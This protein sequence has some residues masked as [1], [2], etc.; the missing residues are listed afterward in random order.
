MVNGHGTLATHERIDRSC[1]VLGSAS[2]RRVI[3]AL[4]QDSP[5]TPDELA[6][7]VV[8]AGISDGRR[9]VLTSLV[10]THLPKLAEADVVDYDGPE[11]AVALS[12]GVE[13]LEP[14]LSVTARQETDR[15]RLASPERSVSAVS[16][17]ESD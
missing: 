13:E 14:L 17:T 16:S 10:H 9:R 2:R 11:D 1:D 8:S 6:D 3:Y 15:D 12:D 7:E 4:Q 5:M